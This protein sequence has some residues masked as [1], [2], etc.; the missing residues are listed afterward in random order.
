MSNLSQMLHFLIIFWKGNL[1]LFVCHILLSCGLYFLCF[2]NVA[3]MSYQT[4]SLKPDEKKNPLFCFVG[5][6]V[7]D[8]ACLQTHTHRHIHTPSYGESTRQEEKCGLIYN[9]FFP[10]FDTCRNWLQKPHVHSI[11]VLKNSEEMRYS[12]KQIF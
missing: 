4:L 1:Y 5:T 11:V 10:I 3:N 2:E 12:N 8:H 7:P 9:F 6:R